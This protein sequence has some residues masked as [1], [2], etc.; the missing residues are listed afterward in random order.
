MDARSDSDQGGFMWNGSFSSHTPLNIF[1]VKK[2]FQIISPTTSHPNTF[3]IGPCHYQ[4]IACPND[5][6]FL[7]AFHNVF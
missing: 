3:T 5:L 2:T 7:N 1:L 6:I 4:C